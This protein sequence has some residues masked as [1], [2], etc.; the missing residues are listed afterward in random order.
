M[1]FAAQARWG[2]KP[3]PKV[4]QNPFFAMYPRFHWG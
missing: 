1:L 3:Y 2:A 4:Q